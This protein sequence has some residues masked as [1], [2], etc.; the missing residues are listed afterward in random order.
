MKKLMIESITLEEFTNLIMSTN[1][2]SQEVEEPILIEE[3]AKFLKCS[4]RSVEDEISKGNLPYH[5][6]KKGARIYFFKSELNDWIKSPSKEE[7]NSL[8]ENTL[9][10]WRQ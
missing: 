2:P 10:S 1:P 6:K 4:K 5:Q 3:A 9:K 7:K 8:L